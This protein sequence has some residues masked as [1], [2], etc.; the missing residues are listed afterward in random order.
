[1]E[2]DS[3][4]KV[5]DQ[6]LMTSQNPFMSPLGEERLKAL[7]EM[8][9][10]ETPSSDKASLLISGEEGLPT[11]YGKKAD[12]LS[13]K[14][15]KKTSSEFDSFVDPLKGVSLADTLHML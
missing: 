15:R 10:P 5:E 14:K 1:M 12:P 11:K 8:E 4:E 3:K 2:G 13:S 7:N 9:T 6:N